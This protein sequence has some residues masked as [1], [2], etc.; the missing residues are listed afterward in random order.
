MGGL[1]GDTNPEGVVIFCHLAHWCVPAD[2]LFTQLKAPLLLGL[3]TSVR[4]EYVR[5]LHM[6]ISFSLSLDIIFKVTLLCVCTLT[7]TLTP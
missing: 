6:D 1:Q 4:N 3:A 7:Y 5:P 2:V